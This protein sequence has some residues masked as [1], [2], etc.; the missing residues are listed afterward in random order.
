MRRVFATLEKV[1][2]AGGIGLQAGG[3]AVAAA[4]RKAI[5]VEVFVK[6]G[7][8][9]VVQIAQDGYLIAAKN[10]TLVTKDLQP[11]RLI[12]PRGEA[13][14][15]KILQVAVDAAHAPDVSVRRANR[16]IAIFKE[17]MAAGKHQRIPWIFVRHDE[18][19]NDER[20]GAETDR[21]SSGYF[22]RPASWTAACYRLK[23][24][25]TGAGFHDRDEAGQ[26]A[27]WSFPNERFRLNR[28]AVWS[29]ANLRAS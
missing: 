5:A 16:C 21:S 4:R 22:L 6:V 29:H 2:V 17:I 3:I 7:F 25:W 18:R 28:C 12:K 1:E 19:I 26:V 15:G 10:I 27:L 11:K 8:A 14:P 20:S 13:F 24:C 23:R 9:V